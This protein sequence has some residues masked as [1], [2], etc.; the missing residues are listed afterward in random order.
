[1]IK[2]SQGVYSKGHRHSNRFNS[3][4]YINRHLSKDLASNNSYRLTKRSLTSLML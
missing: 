2:V 4:L 3:C 1:V